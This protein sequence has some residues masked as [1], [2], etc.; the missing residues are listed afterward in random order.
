MI[1][2]H[3]TKQPT[4]DELLAVTYITGGVIPPV[5][6]L[7]AH[8]LETAETKMWETFGAEKQHHSLVGYTPKR[9]TGFPAWAI[10]T[11]PGNAQH[12]LN[13]VADVEWARRKAAAQA[14]A[15]KKRVD[16]LT[17][18][19]EKSAPHF[20]PT[21][22][23]EIAQIFISIDKH[24]LAEK[25]FAKARDVER[26]H[27]LTIDI[28]RH[29]QTF[30]EFLTLGVVDQ[31][32]LTQEAHTAATHLQP[33]KAY[34]YFF[35]LLITQATIDKPVPAKAVKAL[36]QLGTNAGKTTREVHQESTAAYLP[37]PAFAISSKKLLKIVLKALPDTLKTHP[38]LGKQLYTSIPL[39]W[40]INTYI[41]A[42]QQ[43]ALWQPLHTNPEKFITWLDLVIEH[44]NARW[45]FWA[46]SNPDLL[47]AIIANT[48]V[49]TGHRVE[50]EC[51][52][53][54][55]DYLDALI[56][57]G[58]QWQPRRNPKTQKVSLPFNEWYESHHRDLAFLMGRQDL[59][60][61]LLESLS[62]YNFSENL[63][64]LLSGEPTR[65]L[66]GWKLEEIRAKCANARG[67]LEK[68]SELKLDRK[69]FTDSRIHELYPEL[70]EEILHV[71][72]AEELAERLRRGTL[73]EY[74]WPTFEKV[75]AD[76]ADYSNSL[77]SGTYPWVWVKSGETFIVCN[78]EVVRKY[79]ALG[80]RWVKIV[81]T[82]TDL[83]VIYFDSSSQKHMWMW[84]SED[85]PHQINGS[86]YTYHFAEYTNTIDGTFYAGTAAICGDDLETEPAGTQA[87]FGPI[88]ATSQQSLDHV[89]VLPSGEK[90]PCKVF[91]KR[92]AQGAVLGLEIPEAIA[93]AARHDA[94]VS[95]SYSFTTMAT[96][97]T[98][99]SP[100]GHDGD[101]LY[102]ISLTSTQEGCW[103]ISPLGTFHCPQEEEFFVVERPQAGYWYLRKQW[104]T[105]HKLFDAATDTPIA[106]SR[107]HDGK[108]HVLN[109]LPPVGFHQLT[110]RNEKVSTRM[111]NCTT[112]QA[113]ELIANPLT[114]LDFADN[115]SILAAAIAGII[116]EVNDIAPISLPELA[117]IP[118]ELEHLYASFSPHEDSP[119]EIPQPPIEFGDRYSLDA[120]VYNLACE[121]SA[122]QNRGA[123][124]F[125]QGSGYLRDTIAR[126]T[127]WLSWLATPTLNLED[128]RSYHAFL[129]W[130]ADYNVL[131][132]WR[133]IILPKDYSTSSIEYLWDNNVFYMTQDEENTALW[134]PSLTQRPDISP[135]LGALDDEF[136]IPKEEFK[137]KIDEILHW[138]E[139]RH[140][141][142][143]RP[144]PA[145]DTITL[146]DVAEKAS[147]VTTLP[148]QLWAYFFSS[149]YGD[150]LEWSV[151]EWISSGKEWSVRDRF[152]LSERE[153]SS[154]IEYGCDHFDSRHLTFLAVAWH[155]NY[156]AQG[157]NI[158]SIGVAWEQLWGKP[159]IHITEDMWKALPVSIRETVNSDFHGGIRAGGLP[160][161]RKMDR[162][163][164]LYLHLAHLVEPA[165]STAQ[166]LA[167][168]IQELCHDAHTDPRVPLG[169][170]YNRAESEVTHPNTHALRI[171]TEGHLDQLL[172]YLKTG[173]PITG[174]K[175]DPSTS[176][177]HVVADAAKTLKISADAA[178]YFL[179]LLALTTPTDAAVKKWNNWAKKQLD[180]ATEELLE[181][182]LIITAKRTGAKRSVFLPG[183]WLDK[184]DTGP[185]ME[186]WK[187]PHY[188]LWDDTKCRP[189]VDTCPPIL[190]YP[191]LFAEVWERYKSGDVPGYEELTTKRY[192]GKNNLRF[193]SNIEAS[194]YNL[195][196]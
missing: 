40:N 46:I 35:S 174:T 158:E 192:R 125:Y 58:A 170:E 19:L 1:H 161:E 49:L 70:V 69:S 14:G 12:A 26:T 188:L 127:L 59:R 155:D 132:T 189:I 18:D 131:G 22:L 33:S 148:P 147:T 180:Q 55:L 63:D 144:T 41:K 45:A 133:R 67:S 47:N 66:I 73:V 138:H 126:E 163:L 193:L 29:T 44:G 150:P 116:V 175:Q 34:E 176:A 135:L 6:R 154:Y 152:G 177:P 97:T 141:A 74:T 178:R 86:V 137:R 85:Q 38:E 72:P 89:T 136:F 98:S 164:P 102:G 117:A 114:I 153:I 122:P 195:R 99:K 118:Q 191:N 93:V 149:F 194:N 134:N 95:F 3:A 115:D 110:I 17:G 57:A 166:T 53:Y 77:V 108:D 103:F 81:P 15:V 10:L 8:P 23:E 64:V 124:R 186:T 167:R 4:D 187:A 157:P 42:L 65:K 32:T 92:F 129:H 60:E 182:E 90:M 142:N 31:K 24:S 39:E 165:T 28:D 51:S 54:H 2:I 119:E 101:R 68:W 171:Y 128:V 190:P 162:L 9:T 25:Y 21:F 184:S 145:W 37:T 104:G 120:D 121:L 48:K 16:Q 71:D 91:D 105:S 168:Q 5:I 96:D 151:P 88:Y 76:L 109:L 130:C 196:P 159:W 80:K 56:A 94:Q 112:N 185:A 113:A 52:H 20:L 146:A 183:G 106:P 160:P 78:G 156:L 36:T 50:T 82:D 111:R 143:K 181:K 123:A 107:T 61:T 75:A 43:L 83:L 30:T 27:A 173:T 140:R 139:K 7:V 13:L 87:G 169:C 79:H 100:F 172:T 84:L 11:D 179:Q 62:S